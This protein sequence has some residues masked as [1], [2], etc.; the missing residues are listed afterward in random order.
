VRKLHSRVYIAKYLL[1]LP[2]ATLSQLTAIPRKPQITESM[3]NLT[4]RAMTALGAMV[5]I[6]LCLQAFNSS[7]VPSSIDTP[8]LARLETI[9]RQI[10]TL[11]AAVNQISKQNNTTLRNISWPPAKTSNGDD[12]ETVLKIVFAFAITPVW[13]F[14]F[15]EFYKE[16][17]TVAERTLAA[18][19]WAACAVFVALWHLGQ[20]REWYGYFLRALWGFYGGM[21]LS[22]LFTGDNVPLEVKKA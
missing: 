10:T 16:A 20:P 8:T 12:S 21:F 13:I 14:S 4:P 1:Q 5:L 2:N 7:T 22:V 9:D 11:R 15:L 6:T 3:A 17:G 18:G 19:V